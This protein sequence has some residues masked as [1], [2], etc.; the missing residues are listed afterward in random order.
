LPPFFRLQVYAAGAAAA[1]HL[2][3]PALSTSFS[4]LPGENTVRS[5]FVRTDD[6]AI[7]DDAKKSIV[8]VSVGDK[9][10]V[11]FVQRRGSPGWAKLMTTAAYI[12][13]LVEEIKKLL[14]SLRNVRGD[15]I[16]LQLA[17]K[18]GTLF[19]GK[20]TTGKEEPV[21]LNIMD[22]VDEALGKAAKQAGREIKPGDKLCIILD[23]A[24]H[25]V[26]VSGP[27]AFP[28]LPPPL[29]PERASL[30]GEIWLQTEVRLDA[31]RNVPVFYTEE[32]IDAVRRFICEGPSLGPQALMLLG[33]R[34]SGKSCL[35]HRVL[36]GL[37][38]D[39]YTSGTWQKERS[40]PVI[41]DYSFPPYADLEATAMDLSRALARFG[42]CINVPFDMP[43][44]SRAA[45]NILPKNLS[46]FC[47]RINFAGGELWL[48]LDEVHAPGL[49]STPS[50]AERFTSKI[51]SVVEECSPFAR[52]VFTG[53]GLVTLLNS[54][55][56]ARV[57]SFALWDAITYV[58][59]GSE[60]SQET[61]KEMAAL[62]LER[63]AASWPP[64]VRQVITA[65]RLVDKLS[66]S[67]FDEFPSARPAL[68]AYALGVMGSA[69]N[70][71]ADD[72]WYDAMGAVR[73]K[74]EYEPLR[75]TLSALQV[76][77]RTERRVLRAVADGEYTCAELLAIPHGGGEKDFEV[78]TSQRE[79]LA[80]VIGCLSLREKPVSESGDDVVRL[81][82]PY[83]ALLRSWIRR[84]GTLTM[85][86]EGDIDLVRS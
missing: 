70:G 65:E 5:L 85:T 78:M 55:R 50:E 10:H 26:A 8:P 23:V 66:P 71:T 42:R 53:S 39:Q 54:F 30:G 33:A 82:P 46:M 80:A 31:S 48:L 29:R 28:Q 60:P 32:Q 83:A 58:G 21:T 77:N 7:G 22:T 38:A 76:M 3:K 44:S 63:Y 59:L 57:N 72:V 75:D 20:D 4:V 1:R 41:F 14:P 79:K 34:K 62:L 56:T 47:E 61:S 86:R 17:S 52:I 43:P 15:L 16:S 13:D 67:A 36:P 64:Q 40:L 18:D 2:R 12:T 69:W 11:F 51:K 81:Q 68:M 45:L 27:P 84:D 74:L 25:R 35:L 24:A 49:H 9:T 37:I 6:G 73:S 19:T